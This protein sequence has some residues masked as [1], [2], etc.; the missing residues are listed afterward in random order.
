VVTVRRPGFSLIEVI[1]AAVLLSVAIL[2]VAAGGAAALRTMARAERELV[3]LVAGSAV[4]DSLAHRPAVGNG[5]AARG[6]YAV[7]WSAIDTAGL[8]RIVVS[9][10]DPA[11]PAVTLVELA[12]LAAEPPPPLL[13]P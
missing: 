6:D 9:V 1:V 13:A 2:S 5:L 8:V 3:A 11:D 10:R 7:H 12:V 4:L